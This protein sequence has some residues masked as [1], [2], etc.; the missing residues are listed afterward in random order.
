MKFA[1][2]Q[3]KI[4]Y[5]HKDTNL[6]NAE[7]FIKDSAHQ[8]AD[9]IL[10]PEMS[11]TGFSMNTSLTGEED[12]GTVD[13]MKELALHEKIA[14]GFGWVKGKNNCEN[15]YTVIDDK[16]YMIADYVKI[17]PFSFSGEDKFFRGGDTPCTFSYKGIT[18]GIAICYDLRFPEIFRKE[19]G[20]AHVIIVPA[21]WPKKRREHWRT[22]LRARAIENQVYI[23]GVNCVGSQQGLE[24]S[25]DSAVIDA[26]GCIKLELDEMS[27]MQFL[28]ITDD[29]DEIRSGF[30]VLP[31]RR[32]E[33][34]AKWY[35]T[36]K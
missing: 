10:F 2:C 5:E 22:L 21:N 20:R 12:Y 33:L 18:F 29:V 25:G 19:S 35:T 26:N 15:H 23:I 3:Q 13:A 9:I 6:S 24:Y 14:I 28:D 32:Y 31:D 7:K 27:Q 36:E 30:P 17:H 8:G 11:F 1:I 34:Y 16:G 4:Q